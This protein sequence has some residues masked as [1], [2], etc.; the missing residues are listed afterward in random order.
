MTRDRIGL[1]SGRMLCCAWLLGSSFGHRGASA[2]E[3]EPAF[4]VNGMLKMQGGVFVPL[5][6]DQF[7]AH[8][9]VGLTQGSA[10]RDARPCDVRIAF[11]N[12]IPRDHGQQPG[13]PSI[14]RATLQLEAQ[15]DVTDHLGL[16]AIVRGVR[17]LPLPADRFAQI[18]EVDAASWQRMDLLSPQYE[19]MGRYAEDWVH[20]NY[21]TELDLR[22]FYLDLFPNEWLSMRIG[23]QQLMWG[24][25]GG[26]RLLDAVNPDN[27]TW[28][29][30]ALEA[31][32]DTR[33]PLWMWQTNIDLPAIEHSLELL[34]IPML[35]RPKDTVSV[36]LSF[37]GAW[38][39]P[40]PNTPTSFFT[41]KRIFEYPGRNFRDM[42]AGLRWKG[43]LGRDTNYSLVY[44]YTHQFSPPVPLYFD[45]APVLDDPNGFDPERTERAVLGFPRQ[46]L[47]G[48]SLEHSIQPL[49]TTA[50]L[51][52]AVEPNR[53]FSG[54]TDRYNPAPNDRFRNYFL[55][56]K[57]LALNYAL[58]LQRPTMIRFLNPT[59]NVLLVAQFFHSYVPALDMEAD[60][61]R[62]WTQ[63][64]GY[65]DWQA[66]RHSFRVALVARTSYLRG[67]VNVNL[68]GV[69]VPNPYAKDSG[70]YSVD[71]GFRL[72]PHYR[73]NVVVTDFI[74]KDPYRDLGLFRDRDEVSA[75]LSVLF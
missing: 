37:V 41:P 34:W 29:F 18:P 10:V 48:F 3:G 24:E 9:N 61:D 71:V 50:R 49:A 66:Q 73:L 15:W 56:E 69:Y 21:Y 47:A 1:A 65:N 39:V 55:T 45:F 64:P 26:Y 74:G 5:A 17:S 23:R 70:F 51:E 72:G 25:I 4:S 16:H 68:T 27:N 28:H 44:L 19:Q 8:E 53:T 30:A 31:L 63:I 11:T 32:E 6:S 7:S 42:R 33:I 35:D 57:M 60:S 14:A 38:G 75:A 36:P 20:E 2:Q 43:A 46:H 54:R 62:V 52:L 59:Q 40:Y 22:E 13:S 12:C 58:M 67:L